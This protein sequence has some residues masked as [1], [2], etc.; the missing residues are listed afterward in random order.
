MQGKWPRLSGITSIILTWLV[1][2]AVVTAAVA[3]AAPVADHGDQ[4]AYHD[5]NAMAEV[6]LGAFGWFLL[7]P[8]AVGAVLHRRRLGRSWSTMGVL[9]LVG[10]V[11]AVPLLGVMAFLVAFGGGV[12]A[13]LLAFV[14][15]GLAVPFL[16]R[17]TI[18]AN[19]PGSVF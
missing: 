9:W 10:A 7:G 6:L 17:L 14:I 8:V 18:G 19:S 4:G 11:V 15:W 1:V 3:A 2:G 16:A 12:L 13:L 5:P